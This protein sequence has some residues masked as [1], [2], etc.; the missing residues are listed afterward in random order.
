MM[1]FMCNDCLR[2]GN[3][4]DI[5]DTEMLSAINDNMLARHH[6]YGIE[7]YTVSFISLTAATLVPFVQHMVRV[8]GKLDEN[9]AR[10]SHNWKNPVDRV[11]H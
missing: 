4:M 3:L 8:D 9:K 2:Y 6:S 10:T 7:E 5:S 1:T 11:P